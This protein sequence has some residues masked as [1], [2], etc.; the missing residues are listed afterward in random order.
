MLRYQYLQSIKRAL[1]NSILAVLSAVIAVLIVVYGYQ[2]VRAVFDRVVNNDI[3]EVEE[4]S[5]GELEL[6]ESLKN[7][8]ESSIQERRDILD[9]L[10]SSEDSSASDEE[11][12]QL[13]EA[14]S[15]P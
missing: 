14:L 3:D 7:D 2:A 1:I 4:E 11:K 9:D 10:R 6:L 12:M 15:Q 5:S 8:N 13:L